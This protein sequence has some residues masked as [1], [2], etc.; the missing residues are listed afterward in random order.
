M[1]GGI[2]DPNIHRFSD[3]IGGGVGI[4]Y[5]DR[6]VSG[7]RAILIHKRVPSDKI[8]VKKV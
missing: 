2:V 4:R 3:Q 7:P 6:T 1:C 8:S 5:I